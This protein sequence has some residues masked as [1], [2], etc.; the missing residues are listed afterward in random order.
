MA[1]RWY[2]TVFSLINKIPEIHNFIWNNKVY[3]II[4]LF[5]TV[6]AFKKVQ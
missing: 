5:A 1:S 4:K 6:Q 3:E 2:I